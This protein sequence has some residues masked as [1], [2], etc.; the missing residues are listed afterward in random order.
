MGTPWEPTW[1]PDRGPVDRPGGAM[2]PRPGPEA[3]SMAEKLTKRVVDRL[4]AHA[5]PVKDTLVWDSAVPGLIL[6]LRAGSARFAFQYKRHG[7]TRRV[8][9]GGLRAA[10]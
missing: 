2:S 3:C 7:R 10:Y 9:I 1:E 4:I 6:R 5:D 8:S